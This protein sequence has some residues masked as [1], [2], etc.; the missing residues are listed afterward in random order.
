MLALTCERAELADGMEILE[1]GCGWGS[2]SL[3]MAET[4][5]QLADRGD[6]QLGEPAAVYRT[7]AAA[8][9]GITNLQ[10]LTRNVAD[11]ETSWRFDR[12]VSVEMFEHV[13]NHAELLR[14]I[15]SWLKPDGQALCAYLLPPRPAVCVRS[16][17]SP[18]DWMARHF[19]TGGIMPSADLFGNTA[20]TSQS[21]DNGKS[22]AR[23][24]PDTSEA[25][26]ARLDAQRDELLNLFAQ[27]CRSRD[28][29]AAAAAL[30]DVLSGL[31]RTLRLSWRGRMVRVALSV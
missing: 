24:T 28:G 26:L 7:Q 11:F 21:T 12:V 31:R 15:A 14:R 22:M 25:W 10:V 4:V 9:L 29:K 5:S 17:L 30:A 27:R 3:W 6:F 8:E 23:T 1:L 19:F 2:L 13:R 20:I 16:K 18:S